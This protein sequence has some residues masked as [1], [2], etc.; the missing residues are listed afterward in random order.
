MKSKLNK[1]ETNLSE[2]M[3]LPNGKILAHNITPAMARVLATLDPRDQAMHR[4]A[5]LKKNSPA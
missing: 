2:L 1:T 3:I 4:R 5:T